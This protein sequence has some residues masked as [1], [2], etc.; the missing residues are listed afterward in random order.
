MK[1]WK[2]PLQLRE[3]RKLLRWS[4]TSFMLGI[5]NFQP[6]RRREF[7][8][9][10]LGLQDICDLEQPWDAGELC[11]PLTSHVFIVT[12]GILP[13]A[14]GRGGSLHAAVHGVLW[15]RKEL[16]VLS[17]PCSLIPRV[18]VGSSSRLAL[19]L[20]GP[21]K[22][23][24]LHSIK[25]PLGKA[26]SSGAAPGWLSQASGRATIPSSRGSWF[27]GDGARVQRPRGS[28]GTCR[29]ELGSGDGNLKR[30]DAFWR[31]PKLSA[32]SQT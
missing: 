28:A 30:S 19:Q 7:T 3:E 8:R 20:P 24:S 18:A 26:G 9:E 2:V 29:E 23:L 15:E 13:A 22:S 31:F 5:S 4:L 12:S 21:S 16:P 6:S 1:A 27:L 32:F 10:Q 25:N 14:R 17:S 11:G